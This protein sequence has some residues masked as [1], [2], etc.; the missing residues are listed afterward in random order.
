MF[1]GK[2]C[3]VN[4]FLG[5]HGSTSMRTVMGQRPGSFQSQ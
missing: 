5:I 3:T 4:K 2:T 1:I